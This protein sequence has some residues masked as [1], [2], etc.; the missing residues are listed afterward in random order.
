MGKG[1]R[2]A[3]ITLVERKSKYLLMKQ[4]NRYT[5]QEVHEGIEAVEGRAEVYTNANV[6]E[7]LP[8]VGTPLTWSV[9]HRFSKKGFEQAFKSLGLVVPE[10]VELVRGFH[11]RVLGEVFKGGF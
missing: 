9:I 7:A 6:G 4:V 8:G 2:G 10:D 5:A 11:G 3:L 1:H